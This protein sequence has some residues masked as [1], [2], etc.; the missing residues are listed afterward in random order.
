MTK[1]LVCIVWLSSLMLS[2]T[3]GQAQ[4]APRPRTL[5]RAWLMAQT[6]R[7]RDL[8]RAELRERAE[9]IIDGPTGVRRIGWVAVV[10]GETGTDQWHREVR[11]VQADGRRVPRRRWPQLE[12]QRRSTMGPQAEAAARAVIQ[13]HTM[14]NRMQPVGQAV[15]E[16]VND[17]PCWR[18]ELIPRND[19]VPIERYTLWFDRAQGHLVRSRALVRARR[20]ERSLLITTDYARIEGFDVPRHRRLEGTTQMKRRLRTYTI[21]FRYQATYS[22]YRFFRKERP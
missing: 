9:W 15:R 22:D 13:L 4:D 3:V 1:R 17:T 14:V 7:G 21:L 16:M 10:S 5:V 8:A 11:S 12:R 19:Q 6:E 2:A 20:Q 18:V